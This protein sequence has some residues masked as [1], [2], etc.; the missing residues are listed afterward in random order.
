MWISLPRRRN[1]GMMRGEHGVEM[2]FTLNSSF[3]LRRKR[4]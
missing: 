1:E 3:V 2:R 4:D